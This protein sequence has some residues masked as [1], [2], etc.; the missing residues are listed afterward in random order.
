VARVRLVDH[1]TPRTAKERSNKQL[2]QLIGD[3]CRIRTVANNEDIAT[4]FELQSGCEMSRTVVRLLGLKVNPPATSYVFHLN[5]SCIPLFF[6][7]D[8]IFNGRG[9]KMYFFKNRLSF[10]HPRI[11]R[12]MLYTGFQ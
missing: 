8:R 5:S 10:S 12:L 11:N 9:R 1:S 7:H 6:F 3:G 2:L 4:I